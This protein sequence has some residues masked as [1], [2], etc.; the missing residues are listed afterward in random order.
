MKQNMRKRSP[1]AVLLVLC[2]AVQLCVPAAM[3]SNR[4]MRAGD[5]AIAQIEEEE[6]FRAE[7]YSSGG[8][9]YIGYGTECGAED[10]PE[11][12]TREEAELLLM[13]KVEAY[14]AKLNDFFG[15]Y[16]V[17][18][19]QGQF[20][21]L[22]CFSYNFGTGWMSGTSDLVKIARG[23]KDA[24]RLE[25]AHAFGEWCHSGGQAQAGL[26]DRRLQE[27]A[28]YLDDSTRAAE[29]EFA[30]LIINMESGTSYETDFAVYE[31]GKT[32]GSF[33]K[34]EKLGYGDEADFWEIVGLLHDLDFEMYPDEHCIKSQEIMRENGLDE[35]LIRATSSHGYGLHFDGL[36]EPQH[37]M[38][39]ILFATDE[40][41]GLIGAVA[42]MR[43]SKSVSDLEVKSV[44][45][46]YK[47]KKFAAGCSR[48]VIERGAE[49]LGWDLDT[50]IEQTILAMRASI[51][52]E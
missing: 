8:K 13:S 45:K 42:L 29:N 14:E 39:K 31:I 49:M 23:E 27:A 37:E 7:K 44:K 40:L 10:Y 16:D 38:E 25:V 21:A 43:P 48:E 20:D 36:P 15:R 22:I 46:K 34:A 33:P 19:T 28:I 3:A 50:L 41:T 24:T 4:L 9:W 18:P 35:R 51:H 32:Y 12:I 1:L 26:A 2:L 47:D 17:T 11:G 52:V 30:Y 5:A 6:G